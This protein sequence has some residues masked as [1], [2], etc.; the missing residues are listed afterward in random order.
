MSFSIKPVGVY[1]NERLEDS[2]ALKGVDLEGIEILGETWG[3]I[4][5]ERAAALRPDLIVSAYWPV[6]SAY[7]GFEEGVRYGPVDTPGMPKSPKL[8]CKSERPPVGPSRPR[9]RGPATAGHPSQS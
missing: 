7:G 3:Q 2:K 5:V 4:D 9:L 6:E 8:Q 1:L